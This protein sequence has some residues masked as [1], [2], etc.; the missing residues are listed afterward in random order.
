MRR[1]FTGPKAA[2]QVMTSLML[3]LG[4]ALLPTATAS[5]ASP[6][7]TNSV[8][9]RVAFFD[10]A[11]DVLPGSGLGLQ[12]RLRTLSGSLPA[13]DFFAVSSSIP[14]FSVTSAVKWPPDTSPL[15]RW[16]GSNWRTTAEALEVSIPADAAPGTRYKFSVASCNAIG[17]SE[18]EQALITVSSHA[19]WTTRTFRSDFPHVSTFHA[20]G[21]PFATTFMHSDDSIWA[22]SEFSY[23]LTEIKH[24]ANDASNIKV[25]LPTPSPA[26]FRSFTDCHRGSVSAMSE[27]V[28]TANG[29]VWLTFGGWRWLSRAVGTTAS[30]N[31]S[32]VVGFDPATEKFC[33]YLVPGNNDEVTGVASTGAPPHQRIWFVESNGDDGRP[34]LDGFNPEKVGEGCNGGSDEAYVLRRSS[35][36]LEWPRSGSQWPAQIAV[37]PSSS[38]LWITDYDSFALN[39]QLYDEIERVNISNS[40]DPRVVH[41]YV[42]PSSNPASAFG[43]EPWEITAPK[44]S[45]YVYAIDNGDA[46]IVRIDKATGQLQE[47]PIP[48]ASNGESGFG[49]AILGHRLYFTL[50]DDSGVSFGTTSTFG[51]IDLSSW[52]SDGPPNKGTL[53]TGLPAVTDPSSIANYRAIA[54]GPTGQLAITDQHQIIRLSP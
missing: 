54:A 18:P 2:S 5:P 46:E 25:T 9:T 33:A 3:A 27:K 17:C 28:V 11:F 30:V 16:T 48:L 42:V 44:H 50:A 12:W 4:A 1:M 23:N 39:D 7:N 26:P 32:E 34:S 13:A 15:P 37:D 47:V 20:R 43:G 6:T 24:G 52:P 31:R 36:L 38:T 14:R 45:K 22:A 29:W 49:L 53:F 21:Q 35:R 19:D 10:S 41:R 51:Y 40:S 8:P